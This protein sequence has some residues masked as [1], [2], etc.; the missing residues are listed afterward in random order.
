MQWSQGRI[1][2]NYW[3]QQDGYT[4]K[5]CLKTLFHP[6]LEFVIWTIFVTPLLPVILLQRRPCSRST[7]PPRPTRRWATR[8][9]APSTPPPRPTRRGWRQSTQPGTP[10]PTIHFRAMSQVS[11]VQFMWYNKYNLFPSW[12]LPQRKTKQQV[13]WIGWKLFSY[14]HNWFSVGHGLWG[15]GIT[16]GESKFQNWYLCETF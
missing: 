7:R 2:D 14:F 16:M 1:S 13:L 9:T 15:V 11:K 12:H 5:E 3:S 8:P 10:T 6:L 4:S